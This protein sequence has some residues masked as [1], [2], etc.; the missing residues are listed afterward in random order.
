[1]YESLVA[2]GVS[3]D[4][5]AELCTVRYRYVD[6]RVLFDEIETSAL[7]AGYSVDELRRAWA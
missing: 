4:G 6:S 2:L 1:V 5:E 3:R 7:Q